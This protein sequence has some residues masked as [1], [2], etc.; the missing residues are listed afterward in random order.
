MHL[1]IVHRIDWIL[2]E[3]AMADKRKGKS[4]TEDKGEESA[5]RRADKFGDRTVGRGMDSPDSTEAVL[6]AKTAEPDPRATEKP[7]RRT[8]SRQR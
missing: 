7:A 3:D 6:D 4:R 5:K 2:K 1:P 8:D